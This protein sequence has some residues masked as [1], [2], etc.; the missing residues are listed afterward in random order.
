MRQLFDKTID[1]KQLYVDEDNSLLV[2]RADKGL[3]LIL[4]QN[5]VFI[6]ALFSR[7]RLKL[8]LHTAINRADFVSW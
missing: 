1:V 3:H 2:L 8:R 4:F 7:S 5:T 6:Y